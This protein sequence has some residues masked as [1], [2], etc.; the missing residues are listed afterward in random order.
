MAAGMAVTALAAWPIAAW[1]VAAWAGPGS[2]VLGLLLAGACAGPI[3]FGPLTLRQRGTHPAQLGQV[4]SVSI[5]LNVAGFPLGTALGGFLV[6]WSQPV[7]FLAAAIAAALAGTAVGMIPGDTTRC[8][9][10]AKTW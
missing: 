6:T 1:S 4:L 3:D 8:D 10:S 9:R 7:A 5:S 2:L